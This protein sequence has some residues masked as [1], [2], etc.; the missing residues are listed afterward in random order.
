MNRLLLLVAEPVK[1]DFEICGYL[2][3]TYLKYNNIENHMEKSQTINTY[4][5][6]LNQK[7]AN[8]AIFLTDKIDKAPYYGYKDL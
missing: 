7:I 5:V 3:G 1:L 8:I 4:Q 6:N 2:Q